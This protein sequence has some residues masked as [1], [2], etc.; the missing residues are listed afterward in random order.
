MLRNTFVY[1]CKRRYGKPCIRHTPFRTHLLWVSKVDDF[2]HRSQ[3]TSLGCLQQPSQQFQQP[4]STFVHYSTRRSSFTR[5]NSTR[6]VFSYH[7]KQRKIEG[8]SGKY[9]EAPFGKLTDLLVSIKQNFLIVYC[10]FSKLN[11]QLEYALNLQVPY[12][13]KFQQ[14]KTLVNLAIC[15]EFAKVLSANCLKYLKKLQRLGLNSPKFSRPNANLANNSPKFSPAKIFRYTVM[16]FTCQKLAIP[17][18]IPNGTCPIFPLGPSIQLGR[19]T[20]II[21][22]STKEECR[23]HNQVQGPSKIGWDHWGAVC[24]GVR[25]GRKWTVIAIYLHPCVKAINLYRKIRC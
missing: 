24:K 19:E 8:L 12:N 14:G 3:L 9:E 18:K 16:L 4:L 6:P 2:A 23:C 7:Q 21:C 5:Q 1:S 11:Y 17:F 20:T 13:G 15:Y 22:S 25:T 10:I